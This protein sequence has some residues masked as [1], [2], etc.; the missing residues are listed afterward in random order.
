M[1]RQK[2]HFKCLSSSSGSC[3][4]NPSSKIETITEDI[5][6]FM[7]LV[8]LAWYY[9]TPEV[10]K[11]FL[12]W[13]HMRRAEAC[14][15]SWFN[16]RRC[17]SLG[18]LTLEVFSQVVKNTALGPCSSGN[19]AHCAYFRVVIHCNRL[20]KATEQGHFPSSINPR[21]FPTL[22]PLEL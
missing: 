13:S 5:L 20:G 19:C 8:D 4:N 12:T 6:K 2:Q 16:T 3:H 1:T 18:C 11:R 17:K 10:V 7:L 22:E 21:V 15:S 14:F 9:G